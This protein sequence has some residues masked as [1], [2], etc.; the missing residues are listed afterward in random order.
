MACRKMAIYGAKHPQS[1]KAIEKPFFAL[2]DI[3]RF[4][5]LIGLNVHMGQLYLINIRLKDTVF[6]AQIL[7]YLQALDI[8]ALLF[9]RRTNIDQLTLFVESLVRRDL[10]V[11]SASH[12]QSRLRTLHVD[13]ID[14]NSER[15][16]ELF[17]RRKQYR[18][19]VAGDYSVR[20][21]VLDLLGGDL[22]LLAES[23][24][25]DQN[26][27]VELG[28]DF[29]PGVVR[30]LLPERVASVP[31][32]EIRAYLQRQ[33]AKIREAQKSEQDCS[34]QISRYMAVFKLVDVHPERETIVADLDDQS[35]A[36][37]RSGSDESSATGRI[38]L[39]SNQR[40]E[41]LLEQAFADNNRS[42]D[43]TDFA[44]GFARLLKTGQKDKSVDIVGRLLDGLSNTDTGRR[45]KSLNLLLSLLPQLKFDAGRVVTA[46]TVEDIVTRLGQNEETFEYSEL[47]SQLFNALHAEKHLDL[48]ARLCTAMARRRSMSGDVTVFDSIAVK[49]AFEN[50][51]DHQKVDELI[52]D[53]LR[54]N[55]EEAG[56]LKEILV[57]IGSEAVAVALSRIISHPVR[58]I[59]QLTLRIL[60]EMG[61]AALNVF[62]AKVQDDAL[63][64]RD[65]GRREL[66]DEK[67][68][69][70]RNCIFVLGSLNDA[71]AIP[72]LRTRLSDP[73]V[74]VRREVITALEKIGGEDAVDCLSVIADD[75]DREI[76]QAAIMAIGLIGSPDDAPM[77]QDLAARHPADA[78]KVIA[79]LGKLGGESARTYLIGLLANVQKLSDLADGK[80]SK[81]DLK[82]AAVKALGLIGDAESLAAI[83][84]F[85]ESLSGAAKMFFKSSAMTK[86][87]DD[88]L[89]RR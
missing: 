69:I 79:V 11:D 60:A 22:N 50:L 27:L 28:I 68:Y 78:P 59:R 47:L 80:V 81:D 73:D 54:A 37:R 23:A 76:R 64:Q 1:Q 70:I 75:P 62:S 88:I 55:H 36:S 21:L 87:I 61:K 48:M 52:G 29:D 41:G 84:S 74:R 5:T 17:E 67:W 83:R 77:L 8:S 58:A 2:S 4:K 46:L 3:F 38:R 32:D 56:Y 45:Q 31:A 51:T 6:N 35:F 34:A 12:F 42:F 86:T 14:V 33:A 26:R 40:M 66:P 53:L 57:G 19:D 85:K 63:F 7:Q 10:A 82:L 72:A 49:K 44:D 43:P 20:R 65:E 30:Y 18:G 16:Y 15:C 89:S 25:A 13:T 39:E 71:Q 24:G 9:D